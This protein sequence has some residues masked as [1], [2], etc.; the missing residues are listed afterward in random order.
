MRVAITGG[1]SGIGKACVNLFLAKGWDVTVLGRTQPTQK[2]IN[3][4]SLDLG[5]ESSISAAIDE[6]SGKY[7]AVISNA[8]LPPTQGIET[9]IFAVNFLGFRRLSRAFESRMSKG[10]AFVNVASR[11][12][13]DW[14]NNLDQ[15]QAV[16]ALDSRAEIREFVTRHK[17]S[18]IDCYRLSKAAVIAYTVQETERLAQ[19]GLRVNCVS[20]AATETSML[21]SFL[22]S[23]VGVI[24]KNIARIG[25]AGQPEE[26]AQVI[27]FLASSESSWVKGINIQV[28]GGLSAMLLSDS[29]GT[30]SQN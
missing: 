5:D 9:D 28:D 8:G 21:G 24:E 3:F 25:R 20:P 10:G 18:A 30:S 29:L 13:Y 19:I 2:D 23:K 1:A 27:S 4:I 14:Q 12:G 17:L 7:D 26:C 15:V 6:L 16:L 22:G 11:A